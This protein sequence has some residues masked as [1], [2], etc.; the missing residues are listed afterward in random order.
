MK[1]VFEGTLRS[2]AAIF[3]MDGPL[4]GFTLAAL[5]MSNPTIGVGGLLGAITANI[6]ARAFS[7]PR[8][9]VRA[10]I[11]GLSPLLV[12][13]AVAFTMGPSWQTYFI[14]VAAALFTMTLHTIFSEHLYNAFHMGS[15][16]LAFAVVA[17]AVAFHGKVLAFPAAVP[18]GSG[19]IFLRSLGAIFFLPDPFV[20]GGILL[21]M[22]LYSR[23]L[24][25]LTL[26]G[27]YFGSWIFIM[28]GGSA[29]ELAYG[30]VGLNFILTAIAIG[31]FYLLPG[32]RATLHAITAV[33]VTAFLAISAGRIL[34]P[35][36]LPVFSWPFN[37][38][39]ICWLGAI[40]LRPNSA[41]PK[42]TWGFF[43]S[44]EEMSAQSLLLKRV[45]PDW[46]LP[47][48]PVIGEW[49]VTQSIG[50][51]PTH[52]PPWSDAWDFEV[53]DEAGFPFKIPGGAALD[54]Y[55]GYGA[56]VVAVADGVVARAVSGV[57]DNALGAS[58]VHDNFGN[59]VL[60]R[61]AETLFSVYAHLKSG[62]IRVKPGDA[63][64]AGQTIAQCG[65]SGRSPRPHLHFHL[66]TNAEIGSPTCPTQFG[67]YVLREAEASRFV[68]RGRPQLFERVTSI[69]SFPGSH[70]APKLRA[71]QQWK[72]EVTKRGRS[73][74]EVWKS[75]IDLWGGIK[76]T[77]EAAEAIWKVDAHGMMTAVSFRG[78]RSGALFAFFIG[79]S[80]CPAHLATQLSWHDVPGA[81]FSETRPVLFM[82]E[83]CL[84]FIKFPEDRTQFLFERASDRTVIS[85]TNRNSTVRTVWDHLSEPVEIDFKSRF[86][87]PLHARRV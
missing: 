3:F 45:T 80:L 74:I 83:L 86:R 13:M 48:L 29:N 28:M 33:L 61:H 39:T 42:R 9:L 46:F 17:T 75:D 44:P 36:G 11:Y 71:G 47:R 62:S 27:F 85:A 2:Y 78:S 69:S 87:F 65:S 18:M 70:P 55:Y 7:F 58:N 19:E 1:T 76:L 10:G 12:G 38:A 57:L 51:Q 84:P 60:I 6:A 43:G 49:T 25:V 67:Q 73:R 34:T 79:N 66:Q 14:V 15:Q 16:S 23:V 63:V 37:I 64:V 82:K 77:S 24:T 20:G 4:V 5:S 32:P 54:D 50:G 52:Q 31:G 59:Q 35:L 72:F 21:V 41:E 53:M 40:S 26:I 30:M 68:E 8:E 22:F 56:P 81:A